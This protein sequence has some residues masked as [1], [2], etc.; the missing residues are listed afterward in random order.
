MLWSK[1]IGTYDNGDYIEYKSERDKLQ[2][3]DWT[4]VIIY[5]AKFKVLFFKATKILVRF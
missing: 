1:L 2:I 5:V 4:Y 3:K